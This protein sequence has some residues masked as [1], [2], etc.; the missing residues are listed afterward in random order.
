MRISC[1]RL[2]LLALILS[3][4]S[5][6][7]ERPAMAQ[8]TLCIPDAVGVPGNSGPP[9]WWDPAE[10]YSTTEPTDKDPRW[11][12]ALRISHGSGTTERVSLRALR[13]LEDGVEYLYLSW[14]VESDTFSSAVQKV[15]VGFAPDCSSGGEGCDPAERYLIAVDIQHRDPGAGMR[16]VAG[17]PSW[18]RVYLYRFQQ[19]TTNGQD[20]YALVETPSSFGDFRLWFA[21]AP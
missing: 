10:L 17:A 11:R 3:G 12:G 1:S 8:Q 9:I 2:V 15:L 19:A 5:I 18:F 16:T 21:P 13:S 7:E 6:L 14:K 20:R 4:W